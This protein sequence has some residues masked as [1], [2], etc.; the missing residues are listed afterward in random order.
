[1]IIINVWKMRTNRG[2]SLRELEKMSRISKATINRIE[3]GKKSPTLDE[4][5]RIAMALGCR[6]SDLYDS[7]FY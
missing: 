4:L 1:M 6:I 5:E 2:I 7:E 3:N